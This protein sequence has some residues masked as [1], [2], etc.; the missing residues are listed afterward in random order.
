MEKLTIWFAEYVEYIN[1]NCTMRILHRIRNLISYF[2]VDVCAA[3][4]KNTQRNDSSLFVVILMIKIVWF[5]QTRT[6]TGTELINNSETRYNNF[7]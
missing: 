2:Y 6:T 3:V 1:E 4:Y 5:G 7:N